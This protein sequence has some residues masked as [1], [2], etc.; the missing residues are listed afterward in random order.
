[1]QKSKKEKFAKILFIAVLI[2][3]FWL[4]LK[5]LT[6]IFASEKARDFVK[7]IGPVGPAVIIVY[8][9]VSHILAPMAGTPGVILSAA[10]FGVFQTMIYIYLAGLVSSAINF[11]ISKK[12]G[13]K[14]IKKLAGKK[15]TQNIDEFIRIFGTKI[16]VLSR[17]FGFSL[18]EVIS[19]TAGLTVISFK[20][21]FLLT[22]IF[23][24]IPA[25]IFGVV[26]NNATLQSS[27]TLY[28]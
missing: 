24:A 22:A 23:S 5:W 28:V 20:K 14:W 15:T 9:V 16:L 1:M 19:Y 25:T 8:I 4:S 27:L 10:L 3:I 11:Y 21:Y 7:E 18:F 13:R 12:L 2:L 6:P 26:F 17:V